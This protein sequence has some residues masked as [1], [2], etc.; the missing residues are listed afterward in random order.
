[1]QLPVQDKDT[2]STETTS[3]YT[4]NKSP[5]GFYPLEKKVNSESVN[6]HPSNGCSINQLKNMRNSHAVQIIATKSPPMIRTENTEVGTYPTDANTE[7][8]DNESTS[9][10][11]SPQLSEGLYPPDMCEHTNPKTTV[12]KQF[13]HNDINDYTGFF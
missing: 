10:C 11:I 4:V 8:A 3:I 12:N 13:A 2:V 7:S 6:Q 5:V 1:M 9:S